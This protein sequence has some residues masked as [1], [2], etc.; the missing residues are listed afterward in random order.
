MALQTAVDPRALFLGPQGQNAEVLERAFVEALRDHVYWRRGLCPDDPDA[1][2][3]FRQTEAGFVNTQTALSAAQRKLLARL[4]GSVPCHS[5]RYLGHMMGDTLIPAQVGYLAAMLYNPNNVAA[6]GSPVTSQLEE[7][8]AA[9]LAELLGFDP[10]RAWG[11]LCSGGTVA[12]LE[13]LWIFRNLALAPLRLPRSGALP[14][15]RDAAGNPLVG[16][17]P[18]KLL[19]RLRAADLLDLHRSLPPLS[20]AVRKGGAFRVLVSAMAHYSW[21]KAM[22][23]LGL[24]EDRLETIPVD[25]ELRL[26]LEAL[27]QRLDELAAE[28]VPVLAVV[29]IVGTTEGGGVDPVEGIL[30]VRRRH[31]ER[32][33]RWF[34][35]HLD[36]AYGGY[37]RALFRRRDGGFRELAEMQA[38]LAVRPGLHDAM[39]A[40]PGADSVTVDPHKLGFIPYPAGAL[41]LRDGEMRGV[42]TQR[43]AYINPE[44]ESDHLGSYI[45]EGSK[46]GAA[47]SAVWL[48]HRAVPLDE[49]GYGAILE[50]SFR[51]SRGLAE[52]LDNRVFG[53]YVCRVFETPDLDVLLYA[54][55]HAETSTLHRVNALNEMV[56]SQFPPSLSGGFALTSTRLTRTTHGLAPVPFLRRL[57]VPAKAWRAGSELL[58]LRS[59]MM[60]PF[61]ADPNVKAFY[62]SELI[63][64]FEGLL[65][66]SRV[67][68]AAVKGAA[69]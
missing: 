27:E 4:K 60:T 56:L 22:N 31:A 62:R 13:A 8:V 55:G 68:E 11:H 5:P 10:A 64:A 49:D 42:T 53:D 50:E 16:L 23:I 57:G 45:L 24:G 3:P 21:R 17:P 9:D 35:V 59:V 47:A 2:D 19:G 43:A 44:E 36:A 52:L 29:G 7:E 65:G 67:L 20:G 46:P 15:L 40:V 33:G 30:E 69:R 54:F 66:P 41:L 61:V 58:V 51:A 6:E 26:D 37:A 34:F 28:G 18:E 63:K 25:A 32:H 12:N 14:P 48:A 39:A 1:V 38:T